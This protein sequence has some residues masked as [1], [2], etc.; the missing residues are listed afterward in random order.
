[1]N[2]AGMTRV[3][4]PVPGVPLGSSADDRAAPERRERRASEC[5]GVV[6]DA[7]YLDSDIETSG[8]KEP[9]DD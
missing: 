8:I 6:S 9:C 2:E 5:W 4:A 1:M 7:T 3:F